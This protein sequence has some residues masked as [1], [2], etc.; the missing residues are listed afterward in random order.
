VLVF[1]K[2]PSDLQILVIG[3]RLLVIG[4]FPHLQI[5]KF[6]NLQILNSLSVVCC[7]FCSHIFQSS[8]FQINTLIMS[9]NI[10]HLLLV[11]GI[12]CGIYAFVNSKEDSTELEIG[13][14]KLSAEDKEGSRETTILYV[15]AGVCVV[16]GVAL[17]ARK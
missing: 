15:L 9:K 4:L 13:G 2:I 11:L 8:N 6:S 3:Y 5:L 14:I 17:L 7:S 10:A 16:A 1:L 12:G